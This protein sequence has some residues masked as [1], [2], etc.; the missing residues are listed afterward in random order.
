[1]AGDMLLGDIMKN[2][3]FLKYVA[4]PQG[5]KMYILQRHNGLCMHNFLT[6]KLS[7]ICDIC[8]PGGIF[9]SLGKFLMSYRPV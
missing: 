6:K 4:L 9:K 7:E 2:N 1:M 8:C 5:F 3:S